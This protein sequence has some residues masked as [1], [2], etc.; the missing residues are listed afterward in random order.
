MR[1]ICRNPCRND[2]ELARSATR[3]LVPPTESG[4]FVRQ[5][6]D[7]GCIVGIRRLPGISA[8]PFDRSSESVAVA[9]KSSVVEIE[10]PDVFSP[11]PPGCWML[12]AGCWMLD[13]GCWMHPIDKSPCWIVKGREGGKSEIRIPKSEFETGWMDLVSRIQYRAAGRVASALRWLE[14]ALV[15][16]LVHPTLDEAGEQ[17]DRDQ[18]GNRH[19]AQSHVPEGPHKFQRVN[20]P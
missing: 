18:V 8:R 15:D 10:L 4:G 13:A 12:D 1:F 16:V 3:V 20:R 11:H 7:K 5:V 6:A 17:E 9:T 14:L 19:Q 2:Q